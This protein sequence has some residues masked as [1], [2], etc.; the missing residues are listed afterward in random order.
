MSARTNYRWNNAFVT[1]ASVQL[2]PRPSQA[3]FS[4]DN[5]YSGKD[6]S[7]SIKSIN[8][9]ILDGGLTGIFMGSYLQSLTPSLAVG[10]EAMWQRQAINAG[11]ETMISYCAKYKGSDWIAS[12]QVAELGSFSTSYWK[13][14]TDKVQAGVDLNLQ[15]APGIGQGGLMGSGSR[16]E[17]TT[18]IGAKYDFRNS[19]FRAQID[20]TGKLS[21]LYEKRVLP[22][23]QLTFAGE[24]DHFKVRTLVHIVFVSPAAFFGK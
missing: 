23:V 5:D 11:P 20:S 4:L 22:P 16:K 1:R 9:S 3:M 21:C 14:L 15:F 13:K 10:L 19:T 2:A 8:P 17:G 24:M 7:A 6:F 18:T 12:A